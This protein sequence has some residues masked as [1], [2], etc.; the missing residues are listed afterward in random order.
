[1]KGEANIRSIIGRLLST[2][3][4]CF[5]WSMTAFL[6]GVFFPLRVSGRRNLPS[7]G[8]AL[9]VVNHQSFLDPIVV[10]LTSGR[11]LGLPA[12]STL[13]HFRIVAWALESLGAI[14]IERDGV[15]KEGMKNALA[16]LANGRCVAI[17]P[18][19]TRCR[20]GKLGELKPGFLLLARRTK[21]PLFVC[22]IAG[23]F[24]SW[25]RTRLLPWPSPVWVHY[26]PFELPQADS[27]TQMAAVRNAMEAA[28]KIAYRNRLRIVGTSPS[29]G[30]GNDQV[31]A[32]S[33]A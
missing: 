14:P 28:L 29:R 12:R 13:F 23:A 15:A 1:M 6:I 7:R 3:F 33:T 19:G 27:A 20:N 24:E 4:F 16:K 18:E 2:A 26:E 10:G 5:A 22:G 21:A 9:I 32:T 30:L 8:S 17:W 11:R 25:P 31:A